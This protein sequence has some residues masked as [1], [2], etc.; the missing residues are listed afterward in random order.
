[1][2]MKISKRG[3]E[4]KEKNILSLYENENLIRGTQKNTP[5]KK[6]NKKRNKKRL[7]PYIMNSPT[8]FVKTERE[9]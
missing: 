1:M 6:E 2:R 4:K 9:D 5:K 3:P 8:L 7:C